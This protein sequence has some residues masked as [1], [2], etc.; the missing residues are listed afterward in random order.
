[1]TPNLVAIAGPLLGQTF[2]VTEEPLTIGREPS[3]HVHAPDLSLSRAHSVLVTDRDGVMLTDLDSANGT[4]IN[5]IP[6]TTRLLEH[7]DQIKMGDSV[8]LFLHDPANVAETSAVELDD[9][10][11]R[12]TIQLRTEDMLYLR[13]DQIVDALPP[14]PRRAR[15]LNILLRVSATLGSIRTS[16]DLQRT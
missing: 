11:A 12:P 15:D 13:S 3:N 10:M 7:G 5:G 14:T 9:M 6:I 2:L 1:M 16:D 8:F 4:F